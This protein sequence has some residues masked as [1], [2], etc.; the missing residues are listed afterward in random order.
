MVVVDLATGAIKH[1]VVDQKLID[2][3]KSIVF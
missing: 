3:V 2:K 1:S